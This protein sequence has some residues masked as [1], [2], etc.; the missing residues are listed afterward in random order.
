MA[1]IDKHGRT[2]GDVLFFGAPVML[3]KMLIYETQGDCL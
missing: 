3:I 2:A 1:I